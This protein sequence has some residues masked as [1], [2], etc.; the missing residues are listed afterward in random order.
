MVGGKIKTKCDICKK[1]IRGHI[2]N[3]FNKVLCA[4]CYSI[5]FQ[6]ELHSGKYIIFN[7]GDKE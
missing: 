3:R 7:K 5:E 1:D 4:N 2:F 6:K